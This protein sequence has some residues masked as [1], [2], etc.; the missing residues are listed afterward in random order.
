MEDYE[1]WVKYPEYRWVYNKLELALKLGYD[2][3]PACVPITKSGNYIIRPIYNLY[4]MGIGAKI[5]HLDTS[6]IDDMKNHDVVPPGYFWCEA[7]EGIHYSVDFIRTK[8]PVG[9]VFCWEPSCT[10][11]GEED[12]NLLTKFKSWVKIEN[13]TFEL[14]RFLNQI[15]V[16]DINLEFIGDKII[17]I[18]LRTGNDVFYGEEVGTKIVPVWESDSET[19]IDI[20][21]EDP[22]TRY[23]AFGHLDHVRLGYR[24]E[25]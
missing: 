3:G 10:I 23:N 2:A 12:R 5:V 8:A 13:K 20:E 17:E 22:H 4:G 1:A 14:P 9:S 25:R 24:Y 15:D 18:H 11:V 7:F 21:N 6:I 19:S 16:S